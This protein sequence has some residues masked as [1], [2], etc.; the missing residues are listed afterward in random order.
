LTASWP[1]S[2]GNEIRKGLLIAWSERVQI[3]IELPFFAVLILLLGPLTGAGQQIAAGHVSWSL[4]NDRTSLLVLAI[5]PAMVLYFQAVKLFWRLLGEIQSG[6]LEQ[7]CLSPLPTWLTIAAGRLAAAL[8][9]S[10]FT[11]AVTYGIVSALVSVHYAWSPAAL[12]PVFLLI[13]TGFGYSLIIAGMTLI[14]RRIEMLQ[15]GLLLLVMIF[16]VAAL[17]IFTVPGWFAG[18]GRVFPVTGIVASLYGV[19]ISHRPATGLWGTGG[20]IWL[21]L[22]SAGY[23]IA[24]ILAFRFGERRARIHGSLGQY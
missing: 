15:E 20:L 21:I 8:I 12:V 2:L 19:L 5:V 18:I 14:W 9:E 24:G 7:V 1:V 10:T 22:T 23:L 4:R 3:L 6:T 11:V 16:A 13:V 17:P